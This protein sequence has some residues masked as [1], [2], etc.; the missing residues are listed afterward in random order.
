MQKDD[1]YQKREPDLGEVV[2][3]I[4]IKDIDR[5]PNIIL[6][7]GP[8]RTGTTASL[9]VFG[10]VDIPAHYQPLKAVL[11]W[12][13]QDEDREK[14]HNW[15]IPEGS[16]VYIK[17]TMG[18][19]TV[20]ESQFNPLHVLE[21]AVLAS[22]RREK[23]DYEGITDDAR[24]IIREKVHLVVMGRDPFDTWYSWRSKFTDKG[25]DLERMYANFVQAHLTT[26][27][28]RQKAIERG[29]PLTHYAFE[30]YQCPT[31]SI[32]QLFSRLGITTPPVLEGCS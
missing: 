8:C 15:Q 22:L 1:L 13:M 19:Y 12:M 16:Y 24:N 2:D 32:P 4:R 3:R 23:G 6:T 14:R 27:E 18:P 20:T 29:I 11:R 17:E 28:I 10:A 21:G 31:T 9:R 7:I 25:I 30:A 26:E 5:V